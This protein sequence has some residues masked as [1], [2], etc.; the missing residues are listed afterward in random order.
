[1][2][3]LEKITGTILALLRKANLV[4]V[5]LVGVQVKIWS[6]LRWLHSDFDAIQEDDQSH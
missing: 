3:K 1:M 6:Q 4:V 2:L 5:R